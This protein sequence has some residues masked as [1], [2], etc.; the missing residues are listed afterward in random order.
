MF[1]KT[2]QF[3]YLIYGND[4]ELTLFSPCHKKNKKKN[5]PHQNLSKRGILQVWN[6]AQWLKLMEDS[7]LRKTTFNGRRPLTE[8]D[9]Q[10]KTIFAGRQPLMEDILWWKTPFHGRQPS[11]E[12]N[13]WWRTNSDGIQYL[14][15]INS[16]NNPYCT[17]ALFVQAKER[18]V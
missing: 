12:N 3:F 10:W 15:L 11:I 7:L 9:L 1:C 14:W 8:D 18:L 6:F 17:L 16:N 4:N 13:L 2:I 5:N